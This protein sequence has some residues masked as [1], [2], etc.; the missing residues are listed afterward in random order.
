MLSGL[1]AMAGCC[2][3][4]GDNGELPSL[5]CLPQ[6]TVSVEPDG[7][8]HPMAVSHVV[9]G[10]ASVVGQGRQPVRQSL[11]YNSMNRLIAR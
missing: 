5:I 1:S 10:T 8:A 7:Y 4:G 11:A 9:A 2:A 6:A 3:A